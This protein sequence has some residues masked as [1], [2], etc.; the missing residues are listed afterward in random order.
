MKIIFDNEEQKSII[1]RSLSNAYAVCPSDLGYEDS[2]PAKPGC[3]MDCDEC[4]LNCGIEMEVSE[5]K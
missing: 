5:R 4:W 2:P 1:I 3:V